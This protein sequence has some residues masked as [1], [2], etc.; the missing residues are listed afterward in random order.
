MTDKGQGFFTAPER[1]TIA[2]AMARIIPTDGTPGARE[3]GTI[4]FVDRYLSSIDHVRAKPDGSGFEQL[5]GKTA[6]AWRRRIEQLRDTYREGVARLDRVSQE[7]YDNDFVALTD[8][9]QDH[10]LAILEDPA[11]Q[12][13]TDPDR[14]WAPSEHAA[15]EPA[16]QQTNSE[17]ELDFFPLL[18]FHT[19]QGFYADPI[20]GGNR[21]R[22]GWQVI[23]FPGPESLSDVH[24]GHYSVLSYFADPL[25]YPGTEDDDDA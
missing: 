5:Q 23:G 18:A 20:Y 3:A 6:D 17:L 7:Q 24:S 1:E 15:D 21:D 14:P 22:V 11:K 9:Q 2:A 12:D 16:L 13:A 10:V 4:D 25:G 19:R 8:T